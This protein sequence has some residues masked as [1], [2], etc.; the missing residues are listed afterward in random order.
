MN[1][2]LYKVGVILKQEESEKIPFS[3]FLCSQL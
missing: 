3:N 1:T 2:V